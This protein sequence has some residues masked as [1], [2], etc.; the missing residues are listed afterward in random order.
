MKLVGN[1]EVIAAALGAA[2]GI[3]AVLIGKKN[4][5]A[6]AVGLALSRLTPK[7]ED[8]IKSAG[9]KLEA[10][11]AASTTK[12]QNLAAT[13]DGFREDLDAGEEQAILV[14]SPG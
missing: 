12:Q 6:G 1:A 3:V 10:A 5:V 11:E 13:L 14:R 9:A 7:L 2:S 8:A 4:K